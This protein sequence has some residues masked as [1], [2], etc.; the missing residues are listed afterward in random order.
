MPVSGRLQV[1]D[2]ATILSACTAGLGLAQ[3]S[4]LGLGDLLGKRIVAVLPQWSDE[5][6]PLYLYYPS[7]RLAPAKLRAFSEFVQASAA[8]VRGAH[9]GPRSG[10][11]H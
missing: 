10:D 11:G 1:N 8:A 5:R 2:L 3:V 7:R 4:E 9:P 6:F